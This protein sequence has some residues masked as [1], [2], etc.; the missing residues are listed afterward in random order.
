MSNI[1]AIIIIKVIFTNN[2]SAYA[3]LLVIKI[4]FGMG[5]WVNDL[6]APGNSGDNKFVYLGKGHQ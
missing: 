5:I 3:V 4:S 2:E 6:I 1:S